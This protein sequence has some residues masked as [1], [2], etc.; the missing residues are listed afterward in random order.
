MPLLGYVPFL[1][2]NRPICKAMAELSE[3]YGPVVGVFLGPAQPFVSVCGHESAKEALFNDDLNGRIDSAFV[4][5]RTFGK[6][7]GCHFLLF[8][9]VSR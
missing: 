6:R 4:S 7:L 1:R 5:A 2:K 3:I 9:F 8:T